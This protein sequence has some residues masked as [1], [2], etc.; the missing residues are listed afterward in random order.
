[1]L[2]LIQRLHWLAI[3]MN[4]KNIRAQERPYAIYCGDTV[5]GRVEYRIVQARSFGKDARWLVVEK[6]EAKGNDYN[7]VELRAK[8]MLALEGLELAYQSD[9]FKEAICTSK[10]IQKRVI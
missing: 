3:K 4:C 10:G 7:Y 1:M 2:N 5:L 6:V 8:D 9:E